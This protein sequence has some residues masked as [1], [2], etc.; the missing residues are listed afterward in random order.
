MCGALDTNVNKPRTICI[1]ECIEALDVVLL[2]LNQKLMDLV[3]GLSSNF[4]QVMNLLIFCAALFQWIASVVL[5]NKSAIFIVCLAK[6]KLF[7]IGIV[8]IQIHL[9]LE[10]C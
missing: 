3:Q 7:V 2:M 4:A 5:E 8:G 6:A 10:C 1:V 9:V